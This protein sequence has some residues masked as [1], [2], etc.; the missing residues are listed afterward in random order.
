MDS[1]GRISGDAMKTMNALLKLQEKK[2]T[3]IR[4]VYSFDN[5]TQSHDYA[6]RHVRGV[7]RR[8]CSIQ[9]EGM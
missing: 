5:S 6:I 2:L 1:A 9:E 4:Y 7:W 8:V 3:E